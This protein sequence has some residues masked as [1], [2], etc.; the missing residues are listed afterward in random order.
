MPKIQKLDLDSLRPKPQPMPVP[1]QVEPKSQPITVE[2]ATT[3]QTPRRDWVKI[4]LACAVVFLL[5]YIAFDRGVIPTPGPPQ[6]DIDADG[7]YVMLIQPS[8]EA[9]LSQGQKEFLRSAKVADWVTDNGGEFRAYPQAQDLANESE[10]WRQIRSELSP[11]FVVGVVSD[12]KLTK[13][14]APNGI[15]VGIEALG[16]VK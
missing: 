1:V 9:G 14:E 16:K 11:P 7:F 6:P 2:A 13:L 8:D 4:G 12:R 5:A 3:G 15:D 10:V